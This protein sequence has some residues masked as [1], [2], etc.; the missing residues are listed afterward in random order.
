[1]PHGTDICIIFQQLFFF[2]LQQLQRS[3]VPKTNQILNCSYFSMIYP[4]HVYSSFPTN[5]L[6][7]IYN[8]WCFIFSQHDRIYLRYCNNFYQL[9]N[10]LIVYP[11]SFFNQLKYIFKQLIKSNTP[12]FQLLHIY[13][14]SCVGQKYIFKNVCN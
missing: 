12:N 9:S 13:I 7:H 10:S 5:K 8:V 4:Y 1:M 2:V 14:G 11:V 6:H 3:I